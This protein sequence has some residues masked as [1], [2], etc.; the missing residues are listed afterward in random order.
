MTP[1]V[2][3]TLALVLGALL[4]LYRA[5]RSF[6]TWRAR[7]AVR[8]RFPPAWVASGFAIVGLL[9]LG[10][11]GLPANA[12]DEA[13]PVVGGQNVLNL[14]EA[15]AATAG[16]WYLRDAIRLYSGDRPPARRRH[17]LLHCAVFTA[18]F[19]AIPDRRGPALTFIDDHLSS[20]AC[21]VYITLYMLGVLHLAVDSWRS[22]W[23]R[24][25][26]VPG[27]AFLT[28]FAFVAV[29]AVLDLTYTTLGHVHGE[30]TPIGEGFLDGFQ[31]FFFPGMVVIMVG[32]LLPSAS[33][34]VWRWLGWRLALMSGADAS[35]ALART[36]RRTPDP[37]G[38][39]YALTIAIQG[40]LMDES[41]RL[42]PADGR[43]F[44]RTE[45]WVTRAA[46]PTSGRTWT[47]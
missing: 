8:E 43:R 3:S 36:W 27:R 32:Y 1:S 46:I 34:A 38:E 18:C 9:T 26:T 4:F 33:R 25:T 37:L 40:R 10:V 20:V 11:V 22:A 7:A 5:P 2:A 21:W 19:L 24:R 31:A 23:T 13:L 12:M 14:V 17:L 28:G 6:R 15:L 16:F 42:S 45:R 30:L 29:G 44:R 39:A 47:T 41:L 35:T